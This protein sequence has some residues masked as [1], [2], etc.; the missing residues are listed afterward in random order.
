MNSKG[1]TDFNVSNVN[2]ETTA[3]R[4]FLLIFDK[5]TSNLLCATTPSEVKTKLN[6]V[7]LTDS[8]FDKSGCIDM[9]IG[10]DLLYY[11]FFLAIECPEK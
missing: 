7:V 1:L 2:V 9:L 3:E 8:T 11:T 5:I 4:Q 6:G 10:A